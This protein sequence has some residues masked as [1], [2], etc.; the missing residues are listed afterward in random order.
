MVPGMYTRPFFPST[1]KRIDHSKIEFKGRARWHKTNAEAHRGASLTVE[2]FFIKPF[3]P[4][5]RL[6]LIQMAPTSLAFAA[7]PLLL[8][9]Y[10]LP[11]LF[12]LFSIVCLSLSL[13]L[14]SISFSLSIGRPLARSLSPFLRL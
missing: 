9:S 11:P 12:L 8:A 6:R 4:I 2:N 14:Y 1:V 13:S 10:S 3:S 5:W 7:S